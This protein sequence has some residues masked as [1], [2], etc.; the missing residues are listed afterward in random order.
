MIHKPVCARAT[1]LTD[2]HT[3]HQILNHPAILS[4]WS[5]PMIFTQGGL[6]IIPPTKLYYPLLW[7]CCCQYRTQTSSSIQ[8]Y[9]LHLSK[10]LGT[11]LAFSSQQMLATYRKQNEMFTE[12]QGM[13]EGISTF[14]Y[15][16]G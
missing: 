13:R 16:D 4:D 14:L 9:F 1:P 2:T 5:K 10:G 11:N 15:H 6:Y 8:G 7:S 12:G 3:H